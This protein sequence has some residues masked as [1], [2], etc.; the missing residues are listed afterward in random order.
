RVLLVRRARGRRHAGGRPGRRDLALLS[1]RTIVVDY[2]GTI[3]EQD[4]L[5][6]IAREFGD[7]E[8]YRQVDEAI[9]AGTITLRE[10]ITR[11]YE[12]V[13]APLA[14]VVEWVLEHARVRPGFRDLVELA[15]ARG[16]RLVVL[17][18]GFVELIAPVL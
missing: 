5:D 8:V 16:W 3:T 14:E 17:S 12:P 13:R 10:C 18:S 1:L 4:L 7:P 6:A 2:D 15:R 9:D 11:E